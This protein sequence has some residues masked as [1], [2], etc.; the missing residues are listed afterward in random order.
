MSYDLV[1]EGRMIDPVNGEYSGSICIQDGRIV[2]ITQDRVSG[3]T[4]LRLASSEK[5]FPGFVDPHVHVREPGW[6]H[7]ADMAT[8][9]RA[10]ALGG[11]TTMI[12]NPNNPGQ[13]QTTNKEKVLEKKRLAREKAVID[14]EFLG[15]IGSGNLYTFGEMAGEVVGYKIFMCDSTGNLKLDGLGEAEEAF[16]RLRDV[17]KPVKVH[18]E[19][20]AMNDQARERHGG[21]FDQ[22][23]FL[24]HSYSRPPESEARSIRDVLSLGN[25]FQIPLCI[26]HVS[27]QEGMRLVEADGKARFEATIHHSLL[28]HGHFREL[29]PLGKVNPP[30]RDA[31]DR[32]QVFNSVLGGRVPFVVTDHAPHTLEEKGAGFQDVPSGLPSIEHFG[33]FVSLLLSRGMDLKQLARSTSLNAVE[34]F[35]LG[36]KGRIEEGFLADL[37][38]LDLARQVKIRPP[39]QTKCG[40]SPFEGMEFPGSVSHTIKSGKIIADNGQ[41]R[42]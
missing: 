3:R 18:C 8:E 38:V 21:G 42:V 32:E 19:D 9:S 33:N 41:L 11:V 5:I 34:F 4:S 2:R 22:H 6:E 12:D 20:Q 24:I 27:T 26:C 37:T 31:Q 40:W 13:H 29:G 10:A 30:I 1:L 39:Y 28:D 36:E 17:G 25:R 7:K 16:S 35:G 23:G 15:G 14:I